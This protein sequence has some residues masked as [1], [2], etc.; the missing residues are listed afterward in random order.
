MC[1][2]STAP[3]LSGVFGDAGNSRAQNEGFGGAKQTLGLGGSHS[4]WLC[5]QFYCYRARLSVRA[6]ADRLKWPDW[7][8]LTSGGGQMELA[9]PQV[10]VGIFTNQ[11]EAMQ[12][13]YGEK[14]GLQF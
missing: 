9:K 14:I 4:G 8:A 13:F 7:A 10:D 6:D 11:L 12:A 5:S 3:L 2:C 1:I